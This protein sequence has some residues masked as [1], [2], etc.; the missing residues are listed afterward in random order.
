MQ[1]EADAQLLLV[2]AAVQALLWKARPAILSLGPHTQVTTANVL[3]VWCP[4][5]L[6]VTETH[7]FDSVFW[8]RTLDIPRRSIHL[9]LTFWL[10]MQ[11]DAMQ[12]PPVV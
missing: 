7:L 4:H 12:T 9:Y 5:L 2:C 1:P 10:R 8:C 6:L 3:K 11:K